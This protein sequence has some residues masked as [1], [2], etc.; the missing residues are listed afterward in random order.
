MTTCRPGHRSG[1][2]AIIT[3][4]RSAG[5]GSLAVLFLVASCSSSRTG[6]NAALCGRG[7]GQP[8]APILECQGRRRMR[9]RSW[10]HWRVQLQ[11]LLPLETT[12]GWKVELRSRSSGLQPFLTIARSRVL[13]VE[14]PGVLPMRERT[15]RCSQAAEDAG[16]V[17]M[18]THSHLC[19]T[20]FKSSKRNKRRPAFTR[21]SRGSSAGTAR[22]GMRDASRKGGQLTVVGTTVHRRCSS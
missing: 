9:A 1:S 5:L 11:P 8:R 6:K 13:D 22:L 16:A 19:C 12:G 7:T 2:R 14:M 4:L 18:L 10:W 20:H 3:R 21:L 15:W 17:V